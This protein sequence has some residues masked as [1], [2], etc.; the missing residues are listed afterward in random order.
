MT[1]L[2]EAC[3]IVEGLRPKTAMWS[4]LFFF[5]C[6]YCTGIKGYPLI[7]KLKCCRPPCGSAAPESDVR[8]AMARSIVVL[9][10]RACRELRCS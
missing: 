3:W 8:K 1:L 4:R 7:S 6:P 10:R 9:M 5:I 2:P